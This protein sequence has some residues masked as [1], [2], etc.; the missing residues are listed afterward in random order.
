[1]KQRI[2]MAYNCFCWSMHFND[3][4]CKVAKEGPPFNNIN[5]WPLWP[6]HIFHIC[7]LT[8]S[9]QACG[10]TSISTFMSMELRLK[11]QIFRGSPCFAHFNSISDPPMGNFQW[12]SSEKLPRYFH[13]YESE[14]HLAYLV[15]PLFLWEKLNKYLHE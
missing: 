15:K 4:S 13:A 3:G 11:G 8:E 14:E 12:W 6:T 5:T 7:H 1:M 10:V 9:S 2:I